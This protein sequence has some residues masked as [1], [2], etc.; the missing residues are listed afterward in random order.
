MTRLREEKS[1]EGP[2]ERT[3][4]KRTS[5]AERLKAEQRKREGSPGPA[6]RAEAK[7]EEPPKRA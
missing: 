2:L 4:P 3:L 7:R 1:S 6:E 5:L